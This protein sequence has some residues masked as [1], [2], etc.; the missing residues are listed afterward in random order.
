M[1]N[2]II[3]EEEIGVRIETDMLIAENPIDLMAQLSS[4][5]E[6]IEKMMK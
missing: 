3:R 2:Y 6:D 1:L 4:A 5:S